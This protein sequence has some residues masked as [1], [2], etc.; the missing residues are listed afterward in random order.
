MPF[1]SGKGL[2]TFLIF[3]V[4]SVVRRVVLPV[5]LVFAVILLVF[6][7]I[8]LGFVV[9]RVN[10]NMLSLFVKR[11]VKVFDVFCFVFYSVLLL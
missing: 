6:A 7:V 5:Q 1:I 8:L 4:V 9:V 2:F 10:G 3:G 11:K